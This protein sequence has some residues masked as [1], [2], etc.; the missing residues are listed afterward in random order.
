M[1]Y[2]VMKKSAGVRDTGELRI[3]GVRD[4]RKWG[5]AGVL[6]TGKLFFYCFLFFPNYRPLILTL[7]QQPM[8]KRQNLVYVY[9]T[10]SFDSCS[11]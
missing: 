6:D 5:I 9:Y 3:F 8:K 10:N 2:P 1:G 11:F 7:K 4:T